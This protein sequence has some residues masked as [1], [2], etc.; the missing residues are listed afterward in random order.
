VRRSTGP[1]HWTSVIEALPRTPPHSSFNSFS[2]CLFFASQFQIGVDENTLH[3]SEEPAALVTATIKFVNTWITPFALDE[4]PPPTTSVH[5]LPTAARR[6]SE[7]T[8]V[9]LLGKL[10][11]S[12]DT[13]SALYTSNG[14]LNVSLGSTSQS[15]LSARL[16]NA[17]SASRGHASREGRP[18]EGRSAEGRSAED[19]SAEGR[20]A[21]GRPADSTSGD[22]ALSTPLLGASEHLGHPLDLSV[23]SSAAV[24]R[25]LAAASIYSSRSVSTPGHYWSGHHFLGFHSGGGISGI[26]HSE[27]RTNG[28]RGTRN[29]ELGAQEPLERVSSWAGPEKIPGVAEQLEHGSTG[30]E[31]STPVP[32]SRGSDPMIFGQAP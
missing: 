7:T 8:V 29:R 1:R 19:R 2:L 17:S 26:S 16:L 3:L 6:N 20:P 5:A 22:S 24:N 32:P 31:L 15:M 13:S 12:D 21:E 27:E 9:S 14:N 11:D 18:G 30:Q 4:P 28:P 23:S 10:S 25:R